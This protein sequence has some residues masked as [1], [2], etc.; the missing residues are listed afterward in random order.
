MKFVNTGRPFVVI[1]VVLMLSLSGCAALGA[2]NSDE[3]KD[4]ATESSSELNEIDNSSDTVSA[5]STNGNNTT[6]SNLTDNDATNSNESDRDAG[7]SGANE[8]DDM[9]IDN[10]EMDNSDEADDEIET[11]NDEDNTTGSA[12][13]ENSSNADV[14]DTDDGSEKTESENSDESTESNPDNDSE[15]NDSDTEVDAGIDELDQNYDPDQF[16]FNDIYYEDAEKTSHTVYIWNSYETSIDLSGWTITT[17][18]GGEY[19]F[20][21]GSVLGGDN[22]RA[23][24]FESDELTRNGGTVTLLDA[25]GDVVIETEYGEY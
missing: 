17:T 14:N 8:T 22:S 1:A 16:V 11:R 12:P 5:S 9:G 25:Q 23:A 2:N 3:G 7:A 18:E 15:S 10:D 13:D 4:V 24:R 21:E 6:G 19:V 20:S